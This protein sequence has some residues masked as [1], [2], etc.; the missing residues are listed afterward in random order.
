LSKSPVTR[1]SLKRQLAINA[2][3]KPVNILVP[4]AVIVLGL[5]LSVLV[6]ALPIA[7]VT[8]IV[9][10]LQTFFDSGE[11][12]R[13]GKAA[14]GSQPERVPLDS[15][16]LSPAIARPLEEARATAAAIRRTVV[17]ADAPLDDVVADVDAL[18]VAMETSAKRAQLI[19]STLE[20][21]DVRALDR[22]IAA[23]STD[24]SPDVQALVGDLKAQRESVLR[25]R[26]KLERFQGGMERI[27]S[28]L[29]LLRTRVAEMSASEE[30]A[31]QRELSEQVRGLR[32]RT[33]LLA[34]SMRETFAT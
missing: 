13:V 24:P 16:T 25:L 21:Q 17:E 3:T 15:R 8:Y 11:A 4:A 19:T 34:E 9:L 12:E 1:D 20:G 23:R 26:D 27:C 2:A 14:Y 30:E 22:Q 6:V 32:E 28:S 18:L 29:S 10:S 5:L 33:D 7:V 31:A